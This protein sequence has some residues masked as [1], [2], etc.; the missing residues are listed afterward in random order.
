MLLR[1][2]FLTTILLV[3]V[4][5]TRG[6]NCAKAQANNNPCQPPN[7]GEYLLLV[8]TDT[9]ESQQQVALTLPENTNAIRCLYLDD[10]VTRLGGFTNLEDTKNW[11]RYLIEIGGLEAFVV[12]PPKGVEVVAQTNVPAYNPQSLGNGLAVLVD[13]FNQPE[14]AA[15][16]RDLLETDVGLA[17]FGQRPYLLAMHTKNQEQAKSIVQKLSDRGFWAAI[18]DSRQVVLLRAVVN[19]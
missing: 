12:R 10:L 3:I 6:L 7:A 2:K 9:V 14:V 5:L 11:A 8:A 18:V 19:Y 17:S 16:V 13:Y 1:Q 4:G 15:K